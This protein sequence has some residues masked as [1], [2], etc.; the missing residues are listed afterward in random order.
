MK[1]LLLTLSAL[2]TG[3]AA[4]AAT[5]TVL[6]HETALRKRAQSYAPAVGTARLGQK[7]ETTGE[8]SGFYKTDSGY[9][10]ASAV[11]VKKVKVGSADSTGGTATADE[12]T[13][14][15]RASTRRS[16]RR[17]A[18]RTAPPTSAPSTRWSGAPSRSR[19]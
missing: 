13:S 11:T 18:K 8:E 6:V 15:A 17:T 4:V 12:V 2:L 16:R 10:H 3:T 19:L 7:Y 14:P 5:I 9:I 1:R